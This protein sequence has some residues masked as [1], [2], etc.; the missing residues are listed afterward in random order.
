MLPSPAIKT[1]KQNWNP[2]WKKN[3]RSGKNWL[4]AFGITWFSKHRTLL[5]IPCLPLPKYVVLKVFT[6]LKADWCTALAV[7]R[8]MPLSG[9]TTRR[10]I[11]IPSSL[12]SD[13]KPEMAR[14][15]IRLNIL[16]VSWIRSTKRYRVQ[17]SQKV[18]MSGV[19]P[20]IVVMRQWSLTE[21]PV[22]PWQ[23]VTRRKPKSCGLWL[24][25]VWSIAIVTW[26]IKGWLPLIR[27]N[28]KDVFLPEKP[29]FVPLHCITMRCVRLS[30]WEKI[31][32]SLFLYWV[33][34][35]NR[36]ETFGKIWKTISEPKSK[37]LTRINIMK[38]TISSV[39]GFVFLWLLESLTAKKVRLM[40]CS[41]PA[42]GRKTVCWPRQ[43]VKHFG[44]V[45]PF[46]L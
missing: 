4:Q 14:P 1:V 44:T 26:M 20:A 33:L 6:I 31:W 5:S 25:G 7:S 43:E 38:E 13:M 27:M 41:L 30:I 34:M 46:M 16:P 21:L 22:M 32:R 8:I 9:Q 17:S 12:I 40:P 2:M 10:N 24:N 45:P 39:P 19:G 29:I 3:F 28:W 11:S 18:L 36:Q 23:E 35:K 37:V 42:C 15:L